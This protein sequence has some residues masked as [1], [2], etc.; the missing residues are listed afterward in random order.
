MFRTI[1]LVLAGCLFL[2]VPGFAGESAGRHSGRVLDVRDGTLVME[3][4]GP[5]LGPN[6]GLVT[7]SFA[8]APNAMVRVIRPT[9][10]WTTDASPGYEA[11]VIDPRQLRP[12]DYV[13]VVTRGDGASGTTI[14]VMLT[15]F[16]D[17]T[18]ASPRTESGK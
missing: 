12:G 4:M 10:H 14:E 9:A 7:R 6:T 5:W 1:P 3:E 8:L 18:A 11:R 2:T 16:V 15:D 13:T 17:G